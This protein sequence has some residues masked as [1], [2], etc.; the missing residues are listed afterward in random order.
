MRFLKVYSIFFKQ[1]LKGLMEYRVDFLIGMFAF[2]LTQSTGLLFLYII[3]QNIN[4]LAGFAI[5]EILLMYGI[6]LIPKGIDHLFFDNIW[7]LPRTVRNGTVDRYLL[8]PISPLY[9]YL[10]ERFQPDAFGEI[11]LGVALVILTTARLG[12]MIAWHHMLG[13]LLIVT[14][15]TLI[16]TSLK[17]LTASTSFWLK[18][19]YPL[20]QVTYNISDYTKYPLPIFPKFIQLIMTFVIPFALISYYPMLYMTGSIGFVRVFGYMVVITSAIGTMAIFVWK[21]GLKHYESAGS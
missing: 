12:A 2:L 17:L 6:G 11:I 16:F 15:G 4:A 3:F 1:Y 19:S 5:E 7:L 20:M 10:I 14:I 13:L 18:N 21:Q 8:R 9:V